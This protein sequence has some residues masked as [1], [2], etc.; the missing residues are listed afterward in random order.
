MEGGEARP[1]RFFVDQKE[2]GGIRILKIVVQVRVHRKS[3][4]LVGGERIVIS[5]KGGLGTLRRKINRGVFV[6]GRLTVECKFRT[7]S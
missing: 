5:K 6:D 2:G 4:W 7:S 1:I 3:A